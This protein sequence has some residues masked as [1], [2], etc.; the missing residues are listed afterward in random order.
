MRAHARIE[1]ETDTLLRRWPSLFVR[2]VVAE[3]PPDAAIEAQAGSFG[4]AT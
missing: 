1:W 2:T 3:E 4:L